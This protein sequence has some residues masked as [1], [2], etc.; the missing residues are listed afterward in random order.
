MVIIW[1]ILA[2]FCIKYYIDCANYAGKKST[3]LVFWKISGICFSIL[4]LIDV[5]LYAKLITILPAV[6]AFFRIM[7]VISII[8][9]ATIEL[10]IIKA[11]RLPEQSGCRYMIIPGCQIRGLKLTG[12]LVKRLDRA[13]KYCRDNS[14]II[15][16]VSGGQGRGEDI[17]EALA[18]KQ[19][20][21]EHGISS[22]RIIKE[23]TSESTLQNMVYSVRF[24]DDKSAKTAVVTNNFHVLRATKLAK[25]QGLTNVYGIAAE[26]DKQLFIN[27]MIREAFG[28][29]KDFMSGNFRLKRK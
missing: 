9:L 25:A 26:S 1:L 5:L 19:Y 23:D 10:L 11:M 2:I 27:Y 17:T 4:C 6:I 13:L 7:F 12:S 18:M 22:K 8:I 16:I 14:D 20:L 29:M 21:V 3:F 15:I 28:I 24:I